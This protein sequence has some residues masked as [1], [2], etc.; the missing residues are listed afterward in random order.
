[1]PAQLQ[2]AP[3]KALDWIL[4]GPQKS[5][6][7]EVLFLDYQNPA[8]FSDLWLNGLESATPTIN[9]QPFNWIEG[10]KQILI[11]GIDP[12]DEVFQNRASGLKGINFRSHFTATS[13][14]A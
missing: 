9:A 11:L 13:W 8:N 6:N 5:S 12:P 2:A 7:S 3:A 1:M 4:H 14:L 10:S